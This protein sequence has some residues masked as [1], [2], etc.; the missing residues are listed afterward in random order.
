[1]S[2]KEFSQWM[3]FSSVE[4]I[5]DERADLRAALITSVLANINRNPET[6]PEPFTLSDFLFDFWKVAEEEP[7]GSGWESQL[8]LIEMIN[9]ALGGSDL[10]KK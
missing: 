1:M 4:P 5:G 7:E 10:R 2:S 8:A 6:K 9:C 3:A